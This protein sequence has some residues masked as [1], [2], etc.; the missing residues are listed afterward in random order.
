MKILAL[1]SF[2]LTCC[3]LPL[4]PKLP[5]RY[6]ADV[7][8]FDHVENEGNLLRLV[9]DSGVFYAERSAGNALGEWKS[10]ERIEVRRASADQSVVAL[11]Y[12]KKAVMA[13]VTTDLPKIERHAIRFFSLRCSGSTYLQ[14]LLKHN[15]PTLLFGQDL[16]WK[17]GPSGP[18]ISG[19]KNQASS[20]DELLDLDFQVKGERLKDPATIMIVRNPYDWVRSL[21]KNSWWVLHHSYRDVHFNEFLRSAV[22]ISAHQPADINFFDNKPY[23]NPIEMR[24]AKLKLLLSLTCRSPQHFVINYETLL[25]NAPAVIAHIAS[26]FNWRPKAVYEP[27]DYRIRGRGQKF[28]MPSYPDLGEEELD[29][30]KEQID[31]EL[32]HLLSYEL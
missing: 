3:A 29:F 11:C 16:G 10:G 30:I 23:S 4:D 8:H 26:T 27:I 31:E 22:R 18:A 24:S 15:F 2:A 14:H 19:F 9:F 20:V 21:Y 13:Y 32:E 7:L 17:H 28:E 1:L 25:E 5:K 12:G 6:V